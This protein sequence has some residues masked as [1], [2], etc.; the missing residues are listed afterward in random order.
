MQNGPP[1][2]LGSGTVGFKPG[3]EVVKA[4]LVTNMER[5]TLQL[6]IGNK[7]SNWLVRSPDEYGDGQILNAFHSCFGNEHIAYDQAPSGGMSQKRIGSM[8][9]NQPDG[10]YNFLG[11]L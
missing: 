1:L 11:V 5:G 3:G 9:V 7:T 2:P 8:L 6:S 4:W 10:W